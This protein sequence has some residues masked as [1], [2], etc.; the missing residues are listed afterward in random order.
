MFEQLVRAAMVN[1]AYTALAVVL[2]LALWKGADHWLFPDI[3]FITE[4]KQGNVA[5]A[6]LA[7]VLLVFCAHLVSTGLN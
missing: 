1:V 3:D 4:I 6:I 5:A 2:A 7:G